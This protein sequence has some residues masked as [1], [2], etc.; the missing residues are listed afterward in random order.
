MYSRNFYESK[1]ISDINKYS[2][3][4]LLIDYVYKVG[5]AVSNFKMDY[6]GRSNDAKHYTN[7]QWQ[8]LICFIGPILE[9]HQELT[10]NFG[11]KPCKNCP[12]SSLEVNIRKEKFTLSSTCGNSL[13]LILEF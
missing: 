13:K 10:E 8:Q 6:K 3:L 4:H 2:V 9:D 7:R 12:C 1:E 5:C 11:E